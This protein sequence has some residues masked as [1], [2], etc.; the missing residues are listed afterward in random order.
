MTQYQNPVIDIN[1]KSLTFVISHNPCDTINPCDA[2]SGL[3]SLD[4]NIGF[5]ES[6]LFLLI[7][8]LNQEMQKSQDLEQSLTVDLLVKRSSIV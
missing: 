7:K 6:E 5:D 4:A 1:S 8:V 2:I 3:K